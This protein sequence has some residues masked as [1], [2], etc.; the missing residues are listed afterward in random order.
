[1]VFFGVV[2]VIYGVLWI[3]CCFVELFGVELYFLCEELLEVCRIEGSFLWEEWLFSCLLYKVSWGL[4]FLYGYIYV[5]KVI[6]KLL[7]VI[8]LGKVL[9]DY[10][11]F[12]WVMLVLFFNFNLVE[13]WKVVYFYCLSNN[14][15]FFE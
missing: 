13:V 14:K 15:Y 3:L 5:E 4:L 9:L 12:E 6:E 2:D 1:M 7:R 10:L 8:V 11:D